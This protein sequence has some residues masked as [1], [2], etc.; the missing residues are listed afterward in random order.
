DLDIDVRTDKT[1]VIGA[2]I[3]LH[4]VINNLLSNAIKFT[5]P[6]GRIDIKLETD[7]DWLR[8]SVQDSGCGIDTESLAKIFQPFEQTDRQSV[9]A[10]AGLGLGLTIARTI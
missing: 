3:R 4:Q 9:P 2:A 6:R 10:R 5:P 1:L 8:L 7:V